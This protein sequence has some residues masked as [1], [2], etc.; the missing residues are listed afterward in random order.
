MEDAFGYF[1]R[2]D[3]NE[4]SEDDDNDDHHHHHRLHGG[5]QPRPVEPKATTTT[6]ELEE[7]NE[8]LTNVFQGY[9]FVSYP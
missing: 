9:D 5:F 7:V 2:H 1:G 3:N 8:T 4:Y 6:T